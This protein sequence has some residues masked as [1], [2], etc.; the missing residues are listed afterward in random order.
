MAE[1]QLQSSLDF[2]FD[3]SAQS[4][5][6]K[7]ESLLPQVEPRNDSQAV[8][9]PYESSFELSG[10]SC[11]VSSV[12]DYNSEVNDP[13]NNVFIEPFHHRN[14]HTYTSMRGHYLIWFYL[15]WRRNSAP[16]GKMLINSY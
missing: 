14:L 1:N 13:F 10:F 8:S 9:T 7:S 6:E 16:Q 15:C 5:L 2:T 4:E 12:E 11:V 3:T